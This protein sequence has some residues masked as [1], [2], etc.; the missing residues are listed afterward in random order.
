MPHLR[1]IRRAGKSRGS[2]VVLWLFPEVSDMNWIPVNFLR[3]KKEPSELRS[4][5]SGSM[6][7]LSGTEISTALMRHSVRMTWGWVAEH[8]DEALFFLVRK[9]ALPWWY[10]PRTVLRFRGLNPEKEYRLESSGEI[11]HGSSL[12]NAG[13]LLLNFGWECECKSFYFRAV[14]EIPSGKSADP[15]PPDVAPSAGIMRKNGEK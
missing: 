13:F 4:P 9:T 14:R 6:R 15:L 8:Q 1:I 2:F 3:R 12:M 11:I 5:V 10:G 7:N